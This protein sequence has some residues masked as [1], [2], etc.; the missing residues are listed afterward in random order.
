MSDTRAAEP[1][2]LPWIANENDSD[3][4]RAPSGTTE[5]GP[6][7]LGA[8]SVA[9]MLLVLALAYWIAMHNWQL[10][11]AESEQPP[12]TPTTE[13][14][15]AAKPVGTPTHRHAQRKHVNHG[16]RTQHS[17][18]PT[19]P[20]PVQREVPL[21]LP[22]TKEVAQAK[23]SAH[24][25][26]VAQAKS[27]Q[28]KQVA[29]TKGTAVAKGQ[30]TNA[31]SPHAVAS[32]RTHARRAAHQAPLPL[33]PSVYAMRG[34]P[35]FLTRPLFDS[36]QADGRVVQIGAFRDM[37]EAKVWWSAMVHAYPQVGDL[38]PSMI[39]SRYPN[40]TPFYRFRIGTSSRANSVMLCQM[41]QQIELSC[42]VTGLPWR[43]ASW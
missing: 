38:Q 2:R 11:N 35:P 8:L 9:A 7:V 14:P 16:T 5:F 25:K 15:Q 6:W 22:R 30:P 19:V 28:P 20:L 34:P 10:P 43:A 12:A 33:P 31:L 26:Q 37:H 3:R 42:S 39:E 32:A 27:A 21:Q 23:P 17:P 24:A 4:E 41:M 29:P 13:L 36:P 40:G 18:V 1:E